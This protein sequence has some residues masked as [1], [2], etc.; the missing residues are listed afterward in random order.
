[1]VAGRPAPFC[2][3]FL[4]EKNSLKQPLTARGKGE[5]Q[6]ESGGQ[7]RKGLPMAEEPLV[8]CR[9]SGARQKN[10]GQQCM[11]NPCTYTVALSRLLLA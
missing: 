4:R 10:R 11:G 2:S 8:L 1:M 9:S 6:V 5:V 3:G 7:V